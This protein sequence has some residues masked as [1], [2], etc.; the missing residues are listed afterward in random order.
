ML[1]K[2]VHYHLIFC[3]IILFTNCK[4]ENKL[5]EVSTLDISQIT[6]NS[7]QSGGNVI[8]EGG[9][10]VNSRGVVWAKTSNPLL[11]SNDG[12]T[13]EGNGL[14]VFTSQLNNLSPNSI[15]FV[16]AYAT[17]KAGTIY[18]NLQN[19]YTKKQSNI[20]P[21]DPTTPTPLNNGTRISTGVTL[22]WTCDDPDGDALLFDVYFGTNNNPPLIATN[23]SDPSIRRDGLSMKTTYYWKVIAKD[24]KGGITNGQIWNFTTQMFDN[25]RNEGLVDIDGHKYTTIT[26]GTQV[27]TV[28]DLETTHFNDGHKIPVVQDFA[29][30]KFLQTPGC[31]WYDS[32]NINFGAYYNWYAVSR[33]NLCPSGWHVPSLNEWNILIDYVGGSAI[34]GD[35]LKE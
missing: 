24:S 29:T 12:Y 34:A 7:A 6:Y 33:G 1:I 21:N 23:L 2:L 8:N 19:F 26:I 30:W 35:M 20:A 18:G 32:T 27:W 13:S 28:S 15:Y 9:S 11:E 16:K 10:Q 22:K 17:N 3:I 4:K 14:G 5:P 31:C 25:W